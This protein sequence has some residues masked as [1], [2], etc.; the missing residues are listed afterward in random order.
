MDKQIFEPFV[1]TAEPDA[2][3][4][5]LQ[6]E[7]LMLAM[8]NRKLR[9]EIGDLQKKRAEMAAHREALQKEIDRINA[10]WFAAKP[11]AK[12]IERPP[13]GSSSEART[14]IMRF[15][16]RALRRLKIPSMKR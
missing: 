10:Q 11:S 3:I 12:S 6:Q 9:E 7:N 13:A 2:V 16:L 8:R 5:L 15:A 4:D 14:P 1:A